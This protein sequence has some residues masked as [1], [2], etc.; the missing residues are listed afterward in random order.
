MNFSLAIES[1]NSALN[2]PQYDIKAVDTPTLPISL[3]LKSANS[4]APL[5]QRSLS[6]YKELISLLA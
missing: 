2:G 6:S 3:L 4:L 1:L 5:F